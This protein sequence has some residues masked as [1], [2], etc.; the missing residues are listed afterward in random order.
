MLLDHLKNLYDFQESLVQKEKL[1]S[2]FKNHPGRKELKSLRKKIEEMEEEY[3]AECERQREL[4]KKLALDELKSKEIDGQI[5]ELEKRIYGGEVKTMKELNKL[6]NKQASFKN[7]LEQTESDILNTM[8]EIDE[9]QKGLPQKKD[10]ISSLIKEHNEKRLKIKQE[11]D[12]INEEIIRLST[13]AQE[14]EG[15]IPVDLMSKYKRIEKVKPLPVSKIVDG[16][17]SGCRMD[18]SVMVAQEVS[19]HDRIIYCESCGRILF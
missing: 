8:M 10:M 17:C 11:L 3:K 9:L 7:I 12:K 4:K 1:E 19:R 18:V 16:K 2:Y 6:Q 15:K 13:K 14:L 5:Q